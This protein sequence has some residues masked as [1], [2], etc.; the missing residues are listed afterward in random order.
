VA[1]IREAIVKAYE[2]SPSNGLRERV[3]AEFIWERAAEKTL[4]GYR[5]ALS[6]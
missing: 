1:S 5:V 6:A 4:E 3:L 2:A